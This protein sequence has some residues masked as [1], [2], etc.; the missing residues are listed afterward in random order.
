MRLGFK[1][2]GI[3]EARKALEE[4]SEELAG[5]H[6]ADAAMAGAMIIQNEW[7][8]I[9]PFK[10]HTYQRSIHCEVLH[11]SKDRAEVAIGTDIDDP[12]YPYF[13]EFGTSRMSP[14]PS[15]RPAFDAKKEEAARE[16][17]E[18]LLERVG[19]IWR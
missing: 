12:P 4:I 6:L 7:V 5:Q 8:R 9:A 13:L 3:P 17:E 11:Q 10:T 18:A 1:I 2:V 19:L 16:I 14:H 15:A